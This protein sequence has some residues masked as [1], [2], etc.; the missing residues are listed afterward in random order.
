MYRETYLGRRLLW[1]MGGLSLAMMV[2]LL[3]ILHVQV[4]MARAEDRAARVQSKT[5]VPMGT[6]VDRA[7]Y[8]LAYD[9]PLYELTVDG[10]V[11]NSEHRL[12]DVREWLEGLGFPA[13]EVNAVMAAVSRGQR[14]TLK[15]L[16][17]E[18]AAAA[19]ERIAQAASQGRQACVRLDVGWRRHHP[20]GYVAAHVLGF[21]NLNVPPATQGGVHQVYQQFLET[22]R[23]LQPEYA[24]E[25]EIPGGATPFF[26]SPFR[27]DIVLTLNLGVQYRV[28]QALDRAVER[29]DARGGAVVVMDP[30][31]G[32]IIALASRPTFDPNRFYEYGSETWKDRAV[33]NHYEPGSVMKALTFAAAYDTGLLQEDTQIED[34]GA[35]AYEGRVIYNSQRRGFGLVTPAEAL[36]HSLNVATARV[37]LQMGPAIFYRYMEAFG[38]GRKTEVD[39]ANETAGILHEPNSPEWSPFYLATNAFGQGVSIPPIQL[40]RAMAVLAN[41]GYLVHPHVLHGYYLNDTYYELDWPRGRQ[42]IRPETARTVTRWLE[43][44]IDVIKV[45]GQVDG[46]RVAG[47]TGTAQVPIPGGYSEDEQNTFFVGYYPAEAPQVIILVFLE[48]PRLGPSVHGGGHA[49][50]WASN[51]AYP[52]FVRIAESIN[53]LLGIRPSSA[54]SEQGHVLARQGE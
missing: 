34:T 8:P 5:V 25:A 50:V 37:A 13:N 53:P 27:R 19:R 1:V 21:R 47:K 39:L 35:L 14:A 36:A 31:D 54:R 20:H 4:F 44:V 6:I 46:I 18:Q 41:G 45:F 49:E 3:Q 33:E 17:G 40:I 38:I 30:R 10:S 22:G 29:Y 42:V 48:R 32:A 11:I 15:P 2:V 26:P 51:T 12:A 43:G 7:G 16:N 23:G 52:T 24:H 9:V 28:E